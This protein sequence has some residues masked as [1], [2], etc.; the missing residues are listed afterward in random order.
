MT[1]ND[2]VASPRLLFDVI[3]AE[4]DE[5]DNAR[6]EV[7]FGVAMHAWPELDVSESSSVR[8]YLCRDFRASF[9]CVGGHDWFSSAVARILS[10][11]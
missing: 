6:K 1:G 11:H 4:S 3:S 5:R 9:V 8:V 10:R 2:E 7:S